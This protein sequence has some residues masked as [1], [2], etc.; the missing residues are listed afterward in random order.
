MV[1]VTAEEMDGWKLELL[2]AVVTGLLVEGLRCLL[3]SDDLAL[4]RVDVLHVLLHFV[5]VLINAFHLSLQL[6]QQ[7]LLKHFEPQHVLLIRGLPLKPG[8][9]IFFPLR[10]LIL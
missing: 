5:V 2:L 10:L 8:P 7:E 6:F 3:P 9:N 4:H 1:G